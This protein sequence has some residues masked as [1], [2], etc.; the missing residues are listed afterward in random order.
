MRIRLSLTIEVRRDRSGG[1]ESAP[2][3]DVKGALV[4]LAAPAPLGFT[5]PPVERGEP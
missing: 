3:V 4:E 5:I 1:N 2:H